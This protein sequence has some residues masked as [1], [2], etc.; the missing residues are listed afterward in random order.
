MMNYPLSQYLQYGKANLWQI[1]ALWLVLSPT[2]F[3]SSDR[4]HG[5]GPSRVFFLGGQRN[6]QPKQTN[7]MKIPLTL[8]RSPSSEFNLNMFRLATNKTY[9]IISPFLTHGYENSYSDSNQLHVSAN[10]QLCKGI[11]TIRYFTFIHVYN[12][13]TFH[14]YLL[15][16]LELLKY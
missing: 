11:L 12:L 10:S 5:Y 9:K 13:G 16:A 6:L 8:R 3:C 7:N 1:R 2:A 14:S 4:F 15:P